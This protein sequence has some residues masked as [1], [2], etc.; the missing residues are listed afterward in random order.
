ME[1]RAAAFVQAQLQS[2]GSL[3]PRMKGSSIH[4]LCPFHSESTPS[5]SVSLGRAKAPA[6]VFYCFGCHESGAWTKLAARLN[7]PPIPEWLHG[8]EAPDVNGLRARLGRLHSDS[9]DGDRAFYSTEPKLQG[10]PLLQPDT[11]F[12][13]IRREFLIRFGCRKFLDPE[14]GE[15]FLVIPGNVYGSVEFLV[16]TRLRRVKGSAKYLSSNGTGLIGFDEALATKRYRQHGLLLLVEGPRDAMAFLQNGIPSVSLTGTGLSKDRKDVLM[17]ADPEGLCVVFDND[18]AGYNSSAKL[19]R[20]HGNVLPL[21]RILLPHEDS[22]GKM[23]PGDMGK[24]ML[25][26]VYDTAR[27]MFQ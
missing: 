24:A 3:R 5:C 25:R 7:L 17:S 8:M 2:V 19:L 12:G 22:V 23:D 9:P 10:H 4:I 13:R 26:K 15:P 16:R 11:D 20:D 18:D 6:G 21:Q 27:S 14:T 1:T